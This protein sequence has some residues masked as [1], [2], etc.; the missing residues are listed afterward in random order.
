MRA[1]DILNLV[2]SKVINGIPKGATLKIK[3]LD[4]KNY[5]RQAN[6]VFEDGKLISGIGKTNEDAI[7]DA[8]KTNRSIEFG[9]PPKDPSSACAK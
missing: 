4:G 2:D 3:T 5:T 8:L 6:L 1:T 7:R 9:N